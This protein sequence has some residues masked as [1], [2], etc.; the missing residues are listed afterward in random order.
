MI[1]RRTLLT[2]G[3]THTLASPILGLGMALFLP[4]NPVHANTMATRELATAAVTALRPFL[5][6]LSWSEETIPNLVKE[7]P[8]RHPPPQTCSAANSSLDAYIK[9]LERVDEEYEYEE[10]VDNFIDYSNVDFSNLSSTRSVLHSK[11]MDIERKWNRIDGN[12]SLGDSDPKLQIRRVK[13]AQTILDELVQGMLKIAMI[14]PAY[15][16]A[17][18]CFA[19]IEF[20]YKPKLRNAIEILERLHRRRL[21]GEQQEKKKFPEM[22]REFLEYYNKEARELE[23]ER[24]LQSQI[25]DR[26]QQS[27]QIVKSSQRAYREA[28]NRSERIELEISKIKESKRLLQRQLA[29]YYSKSDQAAENVLEFRRFVNTP[30]SWC[31]N[32]KSYSNCNHHEIKGRWRKQIEKRRRQI[33]SNQI[34]VDE[35]K[36]LIANTNTKLQT[37]RFR[38]ESRQEHWRNA[39]SQKRAAYEDNKKRAAEYY[40]L[41][42][43]YSQRS[44]LNP[45]RQLSDSLAKDG[46]RIKSL[47]NE[48]NLKTL[49]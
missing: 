43:R 3:C 8:V 6:W 44:D 9:A 29:S 14:P 33:K 7:E 24:E 22:I 2:S 48:L 21:F 47:L 26:W 19:S 34:I 23:K 40:E 20:V 49:E 36:I 18:S 12:F 4:V 39:Q 28:F 46:R 42:K 25:Y 38:E 10:R 16:A 37:Q 41:E 35:H 5:E 45:L 17:T 27:Y 11:W 13:S 31:P 30:Y 1:T 32:K 15:S